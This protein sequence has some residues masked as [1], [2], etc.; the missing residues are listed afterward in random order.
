MNSI[1]TKGFTGVV[2]SVTGVC[3]SLLPYLE[4]ALRFLSLLIGIAVGIVT[5]ISLLRHKR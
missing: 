5:L 1:L 2:A 4:T 3:V